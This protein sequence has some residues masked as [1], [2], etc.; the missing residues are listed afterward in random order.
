LSQKL[1]EEGRGK[2]EEGRRK[3]GEGRGEKASEG[4][5]QREEV[6]G[7]KADRAIDKS[8]LSRSPAIAVNPLLIPSQPPNPV[9][10]FCS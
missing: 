7:K 10:Q 4:T 2:K 3:R 1:K 6:G 9:C 8:Q 5:R